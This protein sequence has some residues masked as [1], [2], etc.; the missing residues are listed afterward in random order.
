MVLGTTAIEL[1]A[2]DGQARWSGAVAGQARGMCGVKQHARSTS[3]AASGIVVENIYSITNAVH[4]STACLNEPSSSLT[5]AKIAGSIVRMPQS[6]RAPTAELRRAT[7]DRPWS[8]FL[9]RNL[10]STASALASAALAAYS[11]PSA[12]SMISSTTCVTSPSCCS[13]WRRRS[14]RVS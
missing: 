7:A 1:C 3:D 5:A 12:R 6:M 9:S 11:A 8:H 14:P 10:R 2:I 4:A 13:H